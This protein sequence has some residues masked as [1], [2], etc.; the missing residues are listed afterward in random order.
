MQDAACRI[1]RLLR[2]G[3]PWAT[4]ILGFALL[5]PCAT[6]ADNPPDDVSRLISLA[7]NAGDDPACRD[8]LKQ[9]RDLPGL[10][11]KLQA[12][13]DRLIS[14][15]GR[16]MTSPYLPYFGNEVLKKEDFDFGV[17]KDSPLY[18][19][20]DIYR[21]RMLCWVMLGV[22]GIIDDR[23]GWFDNAREA[24][25][26][27]RAAFP[28]N[29]TVRMYLGE[30]VPPAKRFPEIPGAP[31][32]AVYQRE[33]LERLADII[34]WWI[35]HRM[36]ENNEY[37]GG[38][39]DDC[40]MWR[41]WVPVLIG[42]DDPKI[43][44]A[45]ARFSNALM[46]QDHMQGGYTAHI[47]DVEHTAE[48]S[49]DVITPMMHLEPGNPEWARRA[50]RLADLMETLWTGQNERGF[51][52][53]KSTYFSVDRVS[54][55]PRQAC[56]TVYHL[57]AVQPTLLYWQRTNDERLGRLFT[58]WMDT[59]VDAAARNERG[60]AA[61]I[62][63]SAIH[64]PD[65]AIGGLGENWW[66]PEN[67]EESGLYTWPSAMDQML[68]TL[69]LTY[70]MTQNPKYLDPIKSMA[71]IRLEYLKHPPETSPAP[72]TEA[73]C[74]ARMEYLESVVA[75]YRLLTGQT[76][77]DQ[78][79]ARD[80]SPYTAFR[81]TGERGP[82]DAALKA[83]SEALRINFEGYT[84]E[85][86]YTDRVLR[87]PSLLGENSMY[88][89][90][91]P[92]IALPDTNLLYSTATGD[93]GSAGY[94]P[95]NAVRWLTPPRGLAVVVTDSGTAGFEAELFHFGQESRPMAAEL[96]LLAPGA[97]A[98]SVEPGNVS[99]PF[100]VS[101]SRTRLAFELPPRQLC[102]LRVARM[103]GLFPGSP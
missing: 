39:G 75:K 79:L 35:D 37:G 40:E 23:R 92:G 14:E 46:S 59:W 19:I 44:A 64:W 61:G 69:L 34:T 9:L 101:G 22:G 60:K 17:P 47:Y 29:P 80:A 99:Q 33:G 20:T 73:W 42:F 56:D 102:I 11:P 65:G 41:F 90:A 62:I 55:D 51:L 71:R 84:S 57:R 91:V 21:G 63:P 5:V 16:W 74:A 48:D 32:W 24:F 94:F 76:D 2:H 25:E 96:Y 98:F 86:R 89:D 53:F 27:A 15:I 88:P 50:L 82:L 45:Q 13:A 8:Y 93:P 49:A 97:Y 58:A 70:H 7:G 43:T 36:Q 78:L 18:P 83:N 30:P 28:E 66:K 10:D 67:H 38:W 31:G 87:F 12:E 95:L 103:G 77:L 4:F 3:L 68:Q 72:G 85:V 1:R 81:I 100:T 54:A 52:Q 6:A 26:R